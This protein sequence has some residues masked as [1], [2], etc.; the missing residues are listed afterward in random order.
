MSDTLSGLAEISTFLYNKAVWDVLVRKRGEAEACVF[1]RSACAGSQIFP[2]HWGG[3]A[4]SAWTG[5]AETVRACLSFG[6]SGFGY[7]SSDIGGF[8]GEGKNGGYRM[9]TSPPPI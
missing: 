9:W 7:H 5:I 2:V 6:L 1:A 8:K 3:D 4:D